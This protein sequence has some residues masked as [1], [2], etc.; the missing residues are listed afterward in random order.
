MMWGAAAT[1]P[2]QRFLL[3][4]CGKLGAKPAEIRVMLHSKSAVRYARLLSVIPPSFRG[5][6]ILG[7]RIT[8]GGILGALYATL[9]FNC[10]AFAVRLRARDDYFRFGHSAKA[11]CRTNSGNSRR[12][13]EHRS[14]LVRGG[15]GFS[16]DSESR[17]R[18]TKSFQS[19]TRGLT[20]GPAR[21]RAAWEH[22]G[23]DD[24]L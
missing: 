9:W 23:V 15:R 6:R 21:C 2:E 5:H 16:R 22:Y 19:G 20:S 12:H 14:R 24:W 1:H 13:Q 7:M 4:S 3:R 18:K 11:R 10:F 17:N 8:R